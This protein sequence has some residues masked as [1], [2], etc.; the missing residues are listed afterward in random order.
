MRS[1]LVFLDGPRA[2]ESEPVEEGWPAPSAYEHRDFPG[3]YSHVRVEE[4]HA[5]GLVRHFYTYSEGV[6]DAGV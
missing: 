3:R 6:S 2:D 5:A 1:V 4:D